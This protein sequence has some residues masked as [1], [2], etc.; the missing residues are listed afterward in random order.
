MLR[1]I[2]LAKWFQ[3]E[4]EQTFN[5]EGVNSD[6]FAFFFELFLK[7]SYFHKSG[8][9]N[10]FIFESNQ[11]ALDFLESHDF[12][13]D[14]EYFPDLQED[15]YSGIIQNEDDNQK[16]LN[17]MRKV[18]AKNQINIVASLKSTYIKL[19]PETFFNEN[20][21]SIKKDEIYDP[22]VLTQELVDMGYERT[23]TIE[24]PGCFSQKGEVFDIFLIDGMPVRI[25]YFD[26]II[27]SIHQIDLTTQK[28][29]KWTELEQIEIFK[30][31]SSVLADSRILNF[32]N[33]YPRPKPFERERVQVRTEI[34]NSLTEGRTF[35]NMHLFYEYFFKDTISLMDLQHH[36]NIVFFN[37]ENAER[38]Y[39]LYLE[40][41]NDDRQ[42]Y[43]NFG[44][45][46]LPPLNEIF[47]YPRKFEIEIVRINE[48][49]TSSFNDSSKIIKLQMEPFIINSAAQ[50]RT[51]AICSN[52][53]VLI[54]Q[55]NEV[56]ICVSSDYKKNEIIYLLN[57]FLDDFSSKV[58]F[59]FFPLK[60]S[61]IYPNEKMVF[62][63]EEDFFSNKK[64]QRKKTNVVAKIDYDVFAEQIASLKLGDYVIHK[65]YGVARYIGVET[66]V[67]GSNTNDFIVLEYQDSDKVYLPAYKLDMI[68]KYSTST[69]GSVKVS[70]LK[71]A[72]F[73]QV[74]Q[75]A[76]E[77]VKKL[78]F[79]LIDLHAKRKLKKGFAFSPT[80]QHFNDFS[81]S[82]PYTETEDQQ[83]AIDAVIED[84]EASSP[85]DRLVCGD[86]GFGKTE[87]AIRAA[88]KAVLDDKQV[89]ILVPTT[90]LA[91]QHFSSFQER[92]KSFA[93][94]IESVSRLRSKKE[95]IDI[96]ERLIS[97]KIDILIGTHKILNSEF[98]F[99]DLGLLVIDE[100]QRFGVGHKERLKLLRENVDTLT[101]TATPIP[102]TLQMSFLG[103]KELS[104]IKTPPPRRQSIKTYVLKEDHNTIK[105]AIEKELS[106]GGQVFIVHNRVNDIEIFTGKIRELVPQARIIFAHGQMPEKEL[107][108]KIAAFYRHELDV[109]ISTTIIESGLDI[110]NANTMIVDRAET[111]GLSQLHQLRGRIGRSNKKAYAYFIIPKYKKLSDVS[112]KRLKALQ[113]FSEIGSGFSISSS[114]LEIRGAG[115]I[116]GPEQSGHINSIGLELYMELL[117]DAMNELKGGDAEPNFKVDVQANFNAYIPD[118]YISNDSQRLKFYKILSSAKTE[119]RLESEI[120]VI[121]DQFGPLPIEVLTLIY[122]IRSKISLRRL[123][124]ELI[125]TGQK[126]ILIK[127]NENFI[128]EKP[129]FRDKVINLFTQRPKIYKI[130]PDYSINCIFKDKINIEEYNQFI[131]FLDEKLK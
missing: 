49:S 5:I 43:L 67:L 25:N 32:K 17:I 15:I 112:S 109:L 22:N 48:F 40:K 33:S 94:E 57:L 31:A 64:I 106:R 79:S 41:L 107:E 18:M 69:D 77:S 74:K 105:M 75:K 102:R 82:F 13:V 7:D 23:L 127:F 123:G 125:K 39:H 34:F 99:K 97:G 85:M 46:F 118:S 1:D 101:L 80:D 53:S 21:I 92:F 126:N 115:D 19:P 11:S 63:S 30:T 86:V 100:E 2:A 84:M 111:F 45:D 61:F 91:F 73:E 88:Y 95:L 37:A 131:S 108:K 4:P 3:N 122:I 54:Q 110:P 42:E 128:N 52:I 66:I 51:E 93:V 83:K 90:I 104:L 35:A 60:N 28:T 120:E 103:I 16:R 9:S 8:K 87:V 29:Q 68:Q 10:L 72:K 27:E 129:G 81:H 59:I 55:H 62:I 20:S 116:L 65:T 50:H 26:T 71:K 114:D 44:G 117:N 14:F 89:V 56:H 38:D 36:L 6:Q 58:S 76:R 124:V 47:Q 96:K 113:T 70:N 12:S 121:S 130:N 24:E 78:A 98:K 119:E